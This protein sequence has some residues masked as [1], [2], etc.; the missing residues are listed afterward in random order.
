MVRGIKVSKGC[1]DC[2]EKHPACLQFHHR[3]PSLKLANINRMVILKRS[4][5]LLLS[6]IEKCDVLCANCHAKRHWEEA[7]AGIPAR[8]L[9]PMIELMT[10]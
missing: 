8:V 7:P 1:V 4:R 10:A 3:D 9:P 2:G 6:E 5:Q